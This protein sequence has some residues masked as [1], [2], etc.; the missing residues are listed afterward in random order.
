MQVS[1]LLS[2]VRMIG[3]K[4]PKPDKPEKSAAPKA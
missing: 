3:D 4:A 2:K 1:E